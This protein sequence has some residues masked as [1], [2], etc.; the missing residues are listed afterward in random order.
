ML[1]ILKTA[2][3]KKNKPIMT[4]GKHDNLFNFKLNRRVNILD[5]L[6]DRNKKRIGEW[7]DSVLNLPKFSFRLN[8]N[9]DKTLERLKKYKHKIER[10]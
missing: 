8:D 4:K 1:K 6:S 9:A 3:S 2:L 5:R 7:L 10:M